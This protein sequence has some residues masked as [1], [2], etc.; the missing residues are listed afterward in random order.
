MSISMSISIS[1]IYIYLCH[2][3]KNGFIFKNCLVIVGVGKSEICR[4]DW[5]HEIQ[6]GI[7]AI[8][9]SKYTGQAMQVGNS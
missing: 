4:A 1:I 2:L 6:L 3:L 9:R 7:E 5:Q 8:L